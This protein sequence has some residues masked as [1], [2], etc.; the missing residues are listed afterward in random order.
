M[1]T[2]NEL[3]EFV[4]QIAVVTATSHARGSYGKSPG[5]FKEVIAAVL[6]RYPAHKAWGASVARVAAE[7]REQVLIDFECFR[8]FVETN[9]SASAEPEKS[10]EHYK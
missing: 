2:Y 8:K 9:Y 3:A 5:Q 1:Q 4:S 10:G 7:Y 6:G